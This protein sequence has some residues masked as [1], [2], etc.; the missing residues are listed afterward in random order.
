MKSN[1]VLIQNCGTKQGAPEGARRCG[2][3]AANEQGMTTDQRELEQLARNVNRLRRQHDQIA[4]KA[5]EKTH[6]LRRLQDKAADL[7]KVQEAA[8]GE[9]TDDQTHSE[10]GERAGQGL[11]K[12]NEDS[13]SEDLRPDREAVKGGEGWRQSARRARAD[14]RDGPIAGA[15]A[16]LQRRRARRG[17]TEL[18]RVRNTYRRQSAAG[19]RSPHTQRVPCRAGGAKEPRGGL[20]ERM[21]IENASKDA[22]VN[23]ASI[24]IAAADAAAKGGDEK[25]AERPD[26]YESAFRTIKEA[27]GVSD[28][29]E[30]IHKILNQE[31][32]Q[33][34]LMGLTKENQ[35]K[36]DDLKSRAEDLKAKVDEL[37]YSGSGATHKRKMVDDHEES[38]TAAAA[39]LERAKGKYERLHGSHQRQGCGTSTSACGLAVSEKSGPLQTNDETVV[40]PLP[41]QS[42]LVQLIQDARGRRDPHH[43]SWKALMMHPQEGAAATAGQR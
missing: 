20:E 8:G 27:T 22:G 9:Y 14:P 12:F 3:R 42:T 7:M 2:S 1:R 19:E 31:D 25:H 36:M 4:S 37:R 24:A 23:A 5:T 38:L 21:I 33:G 30:V 15:K 32:T 17:A 43:Q 11:I 13:P 28:I 18:E 40:G 29:N 41:V 26:K 35:V 16:S 6:N 10:L 34:N 39:K